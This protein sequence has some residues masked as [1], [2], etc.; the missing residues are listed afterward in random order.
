MCKESDVRE[1]VGGMDTPGNKGALSVLKFL[2]NALSRSAG[3]TKRL[4]WEKL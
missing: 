3:K 2:V 4:L 1:V